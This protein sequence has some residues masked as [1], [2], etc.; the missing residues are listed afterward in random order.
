MQKPLVDMAKFIKGLVPIEIPESYSLKPMFETISSDEK[1]RSGI[2]AF[3]GFLLKLYDNLI[4]NG[5]LYDK[6]QKPVKNESHTSTAG[7]YPLLSH[8]KSILINIGYQSELHENGMSL[9][10]NDCQT[11]TSAISPDG[12]IMKAKISSPNI[13]ETLR[14]LSSCGMIFNGI[15][16]DAK[17][18]DITKIESLTISY[19]DDPIMLTGLKV[20]AVAQRDLKIND[21][22]DIFLR[23][24]YRPLKNEETDITSILKDFLYPLSEKTKKAAMD[25]HNYYLNKGLLCT[26]SI[27]YFRVRFTYMKGSKAIWD[28]AATRDYGYCLFIKAKNTGMYPDV[29]KNFPAPMQKLIEFGYGCEKKRFNIPC[30]HGCH[31][32]KFPL[33]DSFSNFNNDIKI[34]IDNELQY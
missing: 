9:L 8:V 12:N 33:D 25:L 30:Q 31:G 4:T 21:N 18:S 19:P 3:R 34:W 24:D 1:I 10:L 22:H 17:K 23:C 32:F 6:P 15:D 26:I 11:L 7:N 2:L 13:F 14:F 27:K 5:N 20:M 16:L 29:I 28:F